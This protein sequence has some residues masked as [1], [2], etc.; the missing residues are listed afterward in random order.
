MSQRKSKK[1]TSSSSS[2]G[3]GLL[4][5]IGVIIGA[6]LVAIFGLL[7]NNGSGPATTT[8]APPT[9]VS[10]TRAPRATSTPAATQRPNATQRPGTA[11]A[12]NINNARTINVGQGYGYR[13][14]FWQIYFT[15]P[16]GSRNSADYVGG[17]DEN[18]A[19]AIDGVTR[20]LDI[21]AYEFN[22]P[23]ITAAVL[24]AVDRGVVVRMVADTQA[25]LDDEDATISELIDVGVPVV[26]DQRTALMHDKFMILDSQIVW[27]GSWNYTIND[28][29]RNNNSAIVLRSARAVEYYQAEFDEMFTGR[30]FGPRSPATNSGTFTLQGVN[31]GVYFAP[32]NAVNN[33]ISQ[34]LA[35]A[36]SSIRFMAFSFTLDDVA[37]VIQDRYG[38]GVAVQG[39]FETTGSEQPA[40]ELTPLLCAGME[41]R[42]DGNSYFLHHKVFIIDEQTVMVGSFNFSDS[43]TTSNDENLIVIQDATI[44]ALY[45]QEFQ[46]R[47]AEANT[48]DDIVCR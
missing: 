45:T 47:W 30:T 27:T 48:P 3:G 29:Y 1:S 16:T 5:T 8:Q 28:T 34:T 36:R 11:V 9:S 24:R 17:I 21:V 38:E 42:Q 35:T 31:I 12:G 41:M 20:T 4:R 23:A 44:A 43:A 10:S 22:S 32:E 39:I 26:G 46:R 25:G 14:E 40:S 33:V 19:I 18:L 37:A 6:I 15:A 2:S 13:F 7:T